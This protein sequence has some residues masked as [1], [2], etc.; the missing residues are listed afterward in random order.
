MQLT[1]SYV[2]LSLFFSLGVL[3]FV[4]S[5][6]NPILYNVMSRRY[7]LA[8]LETICG[9]KT[10][11]NSYPHSP[12]FT[13]GHIKSTVISMKEAGVIDRSA[14]ALE[15]NGHMT[16]NSC[17]V[18][19]ND[20]VNGLL[21]CNTCAVSKDG[22]VHGNNVLRIHNNFDFDLQELL[23]TDYKHVYTN[24][25]KEITSSF[26]EDVKIKHG[27]KTNTHNNERP[28]YTDSK[29]NHVRPNDC[30]AQNCVSI[31]VTDTNSSKTLLSANSKS[32]KVKC[33]NGFIKRNAQSTFI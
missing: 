4:G 16:C 3:Y 20:T 15:R 29:P 25:A 27:E 10:Q 8:F 12:R 1:A 6:V 31:I 5:T 7:R 18:N 2:L 30:R 21:T 23:T 24:K 14:C 22:H 19:K 33:Q 32:K 28:K 13:N 26:S 17:A 9:S 11:H